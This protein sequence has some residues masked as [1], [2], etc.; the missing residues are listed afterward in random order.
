MARLFHIG[1]KGTN[2]LDKLG[3]SIK[4]HTQKQFTSSRQLLFFT[5]IQ[6][7]TRPLSTDGAVLIFIFPSILVPF[8]LLQHQMLS[9]LLYLSTAKQGR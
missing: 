2:L 8:S 5:T 3:K 6:I 1:E 7:R 9:T 4:L